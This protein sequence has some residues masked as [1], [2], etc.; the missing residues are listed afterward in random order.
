M[1]L[2]RFKARSLF[3]FLA[4]AFGTGEGNR[5]KEKKDNKSV[6]EI[7]QRFNKRYD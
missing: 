5:Q 1:I 4:I 7:H 2:T 6:N 3:I